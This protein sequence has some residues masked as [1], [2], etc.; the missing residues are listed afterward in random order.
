MKICKTCKKR[1]KLT[2]FYISYKYKNNSIYSTEC[3]ECS[4]LRTINYRKNNREKGYSAGIKYLYGITVEDYNK[5][6]SAQKG[7]CAICKSSE[8]QKNKRRF[9]IDH[10]HTTGKVRG[11]L[12]HNCN[13]AIGK[14]KENINSLKNAI[15]YLKCKN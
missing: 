13:S 10:N 7:K 14:F 1:K 3:K 12:C 15:R 9:D 8:T 11:L 2:S 4:K 5:M 6:F